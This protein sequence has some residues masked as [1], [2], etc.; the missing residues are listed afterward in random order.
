MHSVWKVRHQ[1]GGQKKTHETDRFPRISFSPL[2]NNFYHS[3]QPQTSL[4]LWA[5]QVMTS[6]FP[7]TDTCVLVLW[8][9]R[10]PVIFF[11]L[12]CCR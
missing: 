1:N 10:Y 2:F 7:S 12:H 5:L 11:L 9:A 8:I 4:L 6:I 3:A